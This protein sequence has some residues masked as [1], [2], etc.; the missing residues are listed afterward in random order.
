MYIYDGGVCYDVIFRG[1]IHECVVEG[2]RYLGLGGRTA[3]PMI[4]GSLA[5]SMVLS[6]ILVVLWFV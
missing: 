6:L 5:F 3:Y 1:C 2:G 4:V